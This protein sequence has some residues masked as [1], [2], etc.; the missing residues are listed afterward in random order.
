MAFN[1]FL[2]VYFFLA[3]FAVYYLARK[4]LAVQNIMLL[5]GSYIF[6]SAW[7]IRF[8]PLIVTCTLVNYYSALQIATASSQKKRKIFLVLSMVVSLGILAFFKYYNFFAGN[9]VVLLKSLGVSMNFETLKIILPIGISFYTFQGMGYT[10]D[11][12]QDRVKP[13]RSL[14]NFAVFVSFFPQLV[15]GPIERTSNLLPQVEN[16]R[17]F[18]PEQFS[19]G[20]NLVIFGFFKKVVIADNLA[21]VADAVFNNP[22]KHSGVGVILGVIAFCFQIYCDFSG[23]SYIARGISRWMG[24]K[25]MVN[26]NLPYLS[27]KP[28]EFWQRWHISLSAW[29]RDY[30]FLPIAYAVMNRFPPGKKTR[31]K[32]ETVSYSVAIFITMF[33]GGL[34]HGASWNFVIWGAFH[35][36]LLVVYRLAGTF[37]KTRKLLKL[38]FKRFGI[39]FIPAA[40]SWLVWFIMVNIGWIFF[41]GRD[42]DQISDVFSHIGFGTSHLSPFVLKTVLFLVV[43]FFLYQ[44]FRYFKKDATGTDWIG[45]VPVPAKVF[46]YLL[47]WYVMIIYG[48]TDTVEFIYFQF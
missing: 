41:R 5:V 11:V 25:L 45:R 19:E 21:L 29:L 7:D 13:T 34:W 36:L 8:L 12:Y 40:L 46:V 16:K 18:S 9:F 33:L 32:P 22:A 15:A 2:F 37:K 20:L 28:A 44:V 14:I 4:N 27:R 31:F 48:V 3:F 30:L 23:Y 42:L 1:S 26:F 24:F 17:T 10:I 43:P 47:L 6:Y 39:S 38:L 35:G